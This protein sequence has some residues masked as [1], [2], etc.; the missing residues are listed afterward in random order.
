MSTSLAIQQDTD[1]LVVANLMNEQRFTR[2]MIIAETMASASLIPDHLVGKKVGGKFEYFSAEE[3]RANC[4]L[5]VNQAFR[6][7]MDPFAVMPETYV[8]G[9]KLG[10]QGKLV[11]GLV[12][13]LADLEERLSYAY[14]GQPGTD[15][16]TVTVSGKFRGAKEA[17]SVKVSVGQAKT[18]N[19]M[20]KKDPEQKLAYTGATKWARRWCPEILLGILVDDDDH[21]SMREAVGHVVETTAPTRVITGDSTPAPSAKEATPAK[22]AKAP[23][24]VKEKPA[25]APSSPARPDMVDGIRKAFKA[26]GHKLPAAEEI[27]R[28]FGLLGE[29]VGLSSLTDEEMGVVFARR[30]ELYPPPEETPATEEAPTEGGTEA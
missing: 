24:L 12:N 30:F 23:A 27:A 16:F 4:F 26:A 18:D 17:V 20:W 21:P 25:P 15:D 10:Y 9:G 22:A 28:T 5:I 7:G 2:M 11:A 6:W 13:S 8:V 3:I 14:S 19:Q 29:G 1:P